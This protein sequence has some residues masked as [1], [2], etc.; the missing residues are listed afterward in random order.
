[1]NSLS[2]YALEVPYSP[3]SF[4]C[5]RLRTRDTNYLSSPRI[6]DRL[7]NSVRPR[8]LVFASTLLLK[9][10]QARDI[11]YP[12]T[13]TVCYA[14]ISSMV[15]GKPQLDSIRLR[16]SVFVSVPLLRLECEQEI[17]IIP[18][19]LQIQYNSLDSVRLEISCSLLRLHSA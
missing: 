14:S 5:L 16:G 11:Y 9:G 19:L 7:L 6:H 4:Y 3:L 18:V 12:S 17:R 13:T 15:L 1:M 2:R 10:L 8:G